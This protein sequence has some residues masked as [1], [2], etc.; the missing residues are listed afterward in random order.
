MSHYGEI[1]KDVLNI[2]ANA[3][4]EARKRVSEQTLEQLI[5]LYDYLLKSGG[6]LVFIGVGKSGHI[7]AKIASTFSS[8]GLNSFFLHPVE[9]LHGDMGRISAN[10]VL[11]L[12]S[13]SGTTEEID[14]FLAYVDT[15]KKRI[16]GLLGQGNSTLGK[17]CGTL[18]DCSVQKEACINNQAPTTS[19][20]LTLAMG[21]AIAVVYEKF[22]GLTREGFAKNH[23]AGALGK[24]LRLKVKDL[25]QGYSESPV[26]GAD[27]TIKDVV[28]AM[29]QFPVG[30]CA[31]VDKQHM[32]LG[33]IVEGDFRRNLNSEDISLDTKVEKIMNPTPLAI[34]P[35]ELA[36]DAL[37]KMENL[38]K[39][40]YVLPVIKDKIFQ[41]FIRMH[42]IMREGLY[43][44]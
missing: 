26:V 35:D 34:D 18:F 3:L 9:A 4:L 25:M 24:S 8:L 2:E 31:V 39:Q 27:A 33:L 32:L 43:A 6:Q 40:V 41:G 29:S 30:A 28:L 1:F 36:Y 22:V 16:I 17:K 44:E 10:D 38:T 19:S 21:D 12:I 20:T 5:G 7:G 37:L 15:P 23:P 14:K 42:D 13:K 11:V